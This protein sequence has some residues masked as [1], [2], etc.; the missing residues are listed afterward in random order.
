MIK[1]QA[2]WLAALLLGVLVF[3]SGSALAQPTLQ[4]TKATDTQYKRVLLIS[5]DGIHGV[6]VQRFVA[7]HP[8]STMAQLAN[9]GITYTSAQSAMPSD[10]FPGIL[11][12]TTGGSPRST[13]VYY[14]DSY[15][16]LLSPPGSDCS[17][18]GT[19]VEYAENVDVN[20]D[21]LDGGGG[22]DPK[23]LPR[24]GSKGCAP[25]YPHEFVKV[26]NIFEVIKSSGGRTA[27]SDKHPSYDLLN[28]PSGNGVDDLYN[29]EINANKTTGSV[30]K[31]EA[32]DDIKVQAILNELDG[33][34]HTG[35]NQVGVPTILGMN[36]QAVSVG[37]KLAKN[38]YVDAFATPS[39]GLAD[40]LDHT[41]K[42]LGKM[43]AKLQ[44]NNLLNSTLIIITAKH[45]QAPIDPSKRKIVASSTI[46]DLVNQVAPDLVAQ[47]TQDSVALLWLS[48]Q[49]K[50]EAAVYQL[51]YGPN[52]A[53]AGIQDILADDSLKMMFP[54]PRSDSRSPDI[55]ILPDKGVIY[56]GS[57]ST[58]TAE[59]GGF[60]RDDT[61][62]G[63]I[64]SNPALRAS[65]IKSPVQ[66]TQIAPT[67]LKALGLDPQS[68]QAVVIESTPILPGM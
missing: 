8:N 6:D 16:R 10:S 57:K 15:D 37:Q 1:R 43:V 66:T 27:W 41:D 18:K 39:D 40:A 36:F 12:I 11:A 28:G 2:R 59:H 68:L 14:D 53:L 35:K 47:A 45:G 3:S 42:S 54:D 32:Y 49:S 17:V 5:I 62:V 19:E 61:S 52:Q 30:A 9:T 44:A 29:P 65:T 22:I 67:I 23:K 64:I 48:D 21:A 58:K 63:L 24:D 38:A 4:P 7:S 34:D 13:G 46:P 51:S 55:I 60:S 26:N 56:A 31:T 25:V 50:T 20:P 33:F